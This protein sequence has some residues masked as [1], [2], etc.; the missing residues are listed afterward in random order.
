MPR[1]YFDF[2]S[3]S[4]QNCDHVGSELADD[5]AA[6][7]EAVAAAAQW[8]KDHASAEGTELTVHIRNG[9][10][11]LGAVTASIRVGASSL[12]SVRNGTENQVPFRDIPSKSIETSVP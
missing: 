7:V 6:H 5:H 3:L 11:S 12:S 2:Q 9:N 8:L 1:Y 4:S 10:Q